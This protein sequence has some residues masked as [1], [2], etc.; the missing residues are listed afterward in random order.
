MGIIPATQQRDRSRQNVR[1]ADAFMRLPDREIAGCIVDIGLDFEVADLR[2]PKPDQIQSI[3]ERFVSLL[4]NA[5]PTTVEPAMR[6][7]AE[8]VC[9]GPCVHFLQHVQFT[10]LLEIAADGA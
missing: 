3:F 5:T 7:A 1:E 6:A 8:D 2:T 9:G 10:R 4:L